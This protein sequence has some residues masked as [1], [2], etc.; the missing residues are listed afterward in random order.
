VREVA[1]MFIRHAFVASALAVL[2]YASPTYANSCSNVDVMGSYDQ[3]GLTENEYGINA[4][5][6]F[7]I[8]GEE[9]EGRQPMFNLTTV[10]CEKNPDDPGGLEC[11]VMQA[12]VWATSDKPDVDRPNCSLNLDSS[13]YSMHELQRGVLT[14]MEAL[15]STS[16]YDTAL[17]VDRNTKRVYLSYT[18]TK[19]ADNYDRIKAGTCG[20]APRTQ[21]LMNCTAYPRIRN[22]GRT[23]PRY[24]DF[25]SAGDK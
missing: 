6:T 14:G 5:G 22:K 3:S 11:K 13:T 23:P 4:V 1:G 17:T 9:D 24:C 10:N 12:V 8:A 25:S 15:G 21:V 16:C 20:V 7:R 19:Y 18:R 2:G